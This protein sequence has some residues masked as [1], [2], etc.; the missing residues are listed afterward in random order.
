MKNKP[1]LFVA[2]TAFVIFTVMIGCQKLPGKNAFLTVEETFCIG[3]GDC[4]K[5][6]ED[7]AIVLLGGKAVIDPSKCIQCGNCVKVCPNDAIH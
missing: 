7:D 1:I 6:C 4:I 3:C 2:G 5:V